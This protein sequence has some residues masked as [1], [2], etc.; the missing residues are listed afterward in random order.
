MRVKSILIG[1]GG[2]RAPEAPRR[3][4]VWVNRVDGIEFDEAGTVTPD[5]EWELLEGDAGGR[6]ATEYPVRMSRF[7]N[8]SSV[9]LF[10]VRLPR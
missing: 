6:G 3:V 1:T 9:T 5:Q 10:F 7:G 4:K 2:G 8:V